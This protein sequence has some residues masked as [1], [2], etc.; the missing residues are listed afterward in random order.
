MWLQLGLVILWKNQFKS[1]WL[2]FSSLTRF[3]LVLLGLGSIRFFQFQVFKTEPVSFLK[4]LIGLIC[5]FYSLIF[6]IIFSSFF[7]LTDI[8]NF[9][10]SPLLYTNSENVAEEW[11]IVEGLV[12]KVGSQLIIKNREIGNILGLLRPMRQILLGDNLIE[13]KQIYMIIKL[14]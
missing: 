14:W 11:V 10:C 9:F 13:R 4:I 6:S 1:V 2:G 5:F 7:S 3:F 8:L 12:C